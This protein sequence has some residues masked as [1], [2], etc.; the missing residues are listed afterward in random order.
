MAVGVSVGVGVSLGVAVAVSVKVGVCVG[1]GVDVGVSV[2]VG[3]AVGAGTG[4][5]ICACNVAGTKPL[6]ANNKAVEN[7]PATSERDI[8]GRRLTRGENGLGRRRNGDPNY[9]F[10]I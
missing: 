3:V 8:I 9:Q 6:S 10:F 7:E 2:S 4:G 1:V 5:A